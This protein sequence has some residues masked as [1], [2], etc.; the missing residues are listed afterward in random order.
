MYAFS[1]EKFFEAFLPITSKLGSTLFLT[2]G[3]FAI[4]I[5]LALILAFLSLG[6]NPVLGGVLKIWLS[7]FRGTPV[8]VQLFFFVY[9]L[10]PNIPGIKGL[11]AQWH[12]IICLSLAYSSYMSETI[13]GA[14]LSVDRGQFEGGYSV[15]MSTAQTMARV[16]LPQAL[17][18][19]VPPLS[20]NFLEV[21]KGTA[22]ASMVGITEMM[23][24]AKM[25]SSKNLRFME[26]YLAVLFIY[27]AL[28]IL[29]T[30]LQK[31]L[32]RRLNKNI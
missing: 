17:R 31:L 23:L 24:K 32:E 13:R 22:L 8:L 2:V 10:F 3:T 9:G 4:A 1:F 29:F 19:A 5:V 7:F 12:A 14:I 16:V 27:W 11:G 15:G 25:M 28:N 6:K 26:T 20:N 21:F 18:M 30:F